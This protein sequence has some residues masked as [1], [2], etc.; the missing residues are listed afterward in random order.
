MAKH[1]GRHLSKKPFPGLKRV[2]VG[3]ERHWEYKGKN[4]PTLRD[5]YFGNI[6]EKLGLN[7]AS[8]DLDKKQ[9]VV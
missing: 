4:Y 3:R 8:P 2:G 9:E 5:I 1:S 6:M 7:L